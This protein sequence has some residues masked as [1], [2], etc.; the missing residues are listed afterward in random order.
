MGPQRGRN[1]QKQAK[2]RRCQTQQALAARATARRELHGDEPRHPCRAHRAAAAYQRPSQHSWEQLKDKRSL[3]H[4]EVCLQPFNSFG[5]HTLHTPH[6]VSRLTP[7]LPSAL[8][9]E[10]RSRRQLHARRQQAKLSVAEHSKGVFGTASGAR[11]RPRVLVAGGRRRVQSAWS[12]CMWRALGS[13]ARACVSRADSRW[14][15]AHSIEGCT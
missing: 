11:L 13:G 6:R 12:G 3:R 4:R 7:M 10:P 2:W 14:P 5:G 8:A 1:Q 9:Q 15:V